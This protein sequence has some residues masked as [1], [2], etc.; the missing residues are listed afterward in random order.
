MKGKCDDPGK[1]LLLNPALI[2]AK[3]RQSRD[4]ND[5]ELKNMNIINASQNGLMESRSCQTNLIVILW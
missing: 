3:Y 4:S 2:L 5:K 1:Y